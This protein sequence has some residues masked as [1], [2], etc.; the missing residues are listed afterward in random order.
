MLF[1]CLDPKAKVTAVVTGL[2]ASPGAASGIAVFGADRAEMLGMEQGFKVVPWCVKRPSR[3]RF[4]ASSPPR[5][6]GPPNP[7]P[8][9]VDCAT[10]VHP[11]MPG[12]RNDDQGPPRCKGG[13]HPG[14]NRSVDHRAGLAGGQAMRLDWR[15]PAD[16]RLRH[17]RPLP[18]T[19]HPTRRR[20]GPVIAAAG[21]IS[22][23][24]RRAR[25]GYSAP[26][27]VRTP[28]RFRQPSEKP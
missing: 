20:S 28:G 11:R 25:A 2:P 14:E 13:R 23:A 17:T 3:N 12:G 10:L 5:A 8:P 7:T 24:A 9:L 1:P 16:R 19:R 15:Q 22:G 6:S 26:S 18:A 21:S 27:D 4:I